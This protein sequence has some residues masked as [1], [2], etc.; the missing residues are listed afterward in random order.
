MARIRPVTNTISQFIFSRL[1]SYYDWLI[2]KRSIFITCILK[3]N[4]ITRISSFYS[5]RGGSLDIFE[6]LMTSL[7]AKKRLEGIAL[8][9]NALNDYYNTFLGAYYV[10]SITAILWHTALHGC[11]NVNMFSPIDLIVCHCHLR[12][13]F[14]FVLDPVWDSFVFKKN[15]RAGG[16]GH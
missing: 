14:V 10:T 12:P 2:S 4:L 16:A 13:R 7:G 5:K 8:R 9:A 3:L 1:F 15:G 11:Y 6:S